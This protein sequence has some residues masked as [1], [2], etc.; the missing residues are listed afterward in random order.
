VELTAGALYELVPRL[1]REFPALPLDRPPWA[2]AARVEL[3]IAALEASGALRRFSVSDGNVFVHPDAAV[4][5]RAVLRGP[6]VISA[7]CTVAPTAFLRDGVVLGPGT[8]VGHAVELKSCI[9]AGGSALA[10]LGYVGNSVIGSEVN[11][12][13]G[14]VVAN[15]LGSRP[16]T[17]VVNGAAALDTG[18]RKFGALI[19]DRCAIGANSV[20]SPGRSRPGTVVR[21]A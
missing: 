8:H 16:A 15:H 11:L 7:G 21:R 12:E 6:V 13:A 19:G 4:D 17:I 9:V 18:E 3:A 5:A 1:A 10:H 2:L 20:L 14:V